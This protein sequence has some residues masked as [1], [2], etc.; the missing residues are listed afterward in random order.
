MPK[1]VPEYKED[2]KRRIIQAAI[3]VIAERGYARTTID[4]IARKLGVSKGAVYW[5]F[6]SKEDLFQEALQS[7]QIEMQKVAFDTYYNRPLEWELNQVLERFSLT[8]DTRRT[9][10]YEMFALATRDNVARHAISD[11]IKS[12]IST[13]TEGIEREQKQ[14]TI[15]AET[16][17]RTL[18]LILVAISSGML[19]YA[20]IYMSHAE[21]RQV[22]REAARLLLNPRD[23][24]SAD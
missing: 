6:P 7:I 3:E 8:D 1:V 11:Y 21:I 16:D 12:L 4:D 2:A 17:A 13:V 24:K 23:T 10:F 15:A 14:G 20:L 5:Y 18:A 22:W 9:L 19:D